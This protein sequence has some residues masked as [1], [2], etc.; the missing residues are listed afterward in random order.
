[1]APPRLS[2]GRMPDTRERRQSR[3]LLYRE[4]RRLAV[5]KGTNAI[6]WMKTASRLDGFLYFL[7]SAFIVAAIMLVYHD[8][9]WW[10]VDEGVYAYVAQRALAGDV[11]HRDVIDLHAGY[12]NLVNIF[13]FRIFGEDLLS[14][15]YP[16]IAITFLQCAIVVILLKEHGRLICFTGAIGIAAFSF[17]QFP[18]PSANW[19]ALPAFFI[20]CLCLERMQKGSSLRL[21]LAGL[22]VGICFFTRQFSGAILA[23]G[24]ICVL[25]DETTEQDVGSRAPAV[26]IGGISFAGLAFYVTTKGQIFG[27][28][29]AGIW[30]MLLLLVVSLRSRMTWIHAG[31]NTAL[32]F[33]GFMLASLPLMVLALSHGAFSD[34]VSDI[35]V[36]PLLV[37]GA[38]FTKQSSFLYLLQMAWQNIATAKSFVAVLSGAAWI[39]LI[40]SV[41]AIGAHAFLSVWKAQ[42]VRPIVMLSVFWAF[43][44]LFNQIPIYL[45]FVLP[46]VLLAYLAAWPTIIV[47][48]T[49]LLL[50]GWALLFQA[51][52]PLERGLVGIVAGLRTASN[53]PADLPRVTLRLQ[54]EDA[55]M[56]RQLIDAITE[57]ADPD[58]PL[59]TIPMEPEINF[60]TGRKSPTRY[61]S[62]AFGLRDAQ[63]V[64]ESLI[65]LDASAPL[66]VVH[67]RHDKYLTPLSAK[68]LERVKERSDPPV[69]VGLFDLYRYRGSKL[70]TA[71]VSVR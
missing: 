46:A 30:P 42:P 64:S 58:E 3:P 39:F 60:M 44:A 38:D 68:L 36:T 11:I 5:W 48:L 61:Y 27:M 33:S 67:R 8:Q 45:F 17:V 22:I 51:S 57:N 9:F 59:M 55:R 43:S 71:P 24:L 31:Q 12:G 40:V 49:V 13:A 69:A 50:S 18:N 16:L 29:W 20:L 63:D 4:S 52:Q 66:F 70:S 37:D 1:M 23:L 21:F 41:P 28:L 6:G 10:P 65:A 19:H 2:T 62:T 7:L 34:W 14:L 53:V 32:V 54:A 25:L 15:R 56:F 26:V 35:F 47:A